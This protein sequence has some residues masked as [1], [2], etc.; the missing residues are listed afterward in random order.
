MQ[1][2]QCGSINLE[3]SNLSLRTL[4]N[5]SFWQLIPVYREGKRIMI[6]CPSLITSCSNIVHWPLSYIIFSDCEDLGYFLVYKQ[7][8][9][10]VSS[11]YFN[12]E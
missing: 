8:N 9:L 5:L 6:L 4:Q 11:K 1:H 2:K 12:F 3:Y 7:E 10:I